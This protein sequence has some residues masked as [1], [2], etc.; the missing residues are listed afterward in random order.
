MLSF[1]WQGREGG[2]GT[3]EGEAGEGEGRAGEG[4]AGD[5]GA[6]EEERRGEG[7]WEGRG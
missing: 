5:V 3:G 6:G 4:E 1:T 7:G 2:E